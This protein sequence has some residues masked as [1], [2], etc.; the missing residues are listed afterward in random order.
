MR[1]KETGS[2]ELTNLSRTLSWLMRKKWNRQ[3]NHP[4]PL[5]HHTAQDLCLSAL[6]GEKTVTW[7]CLQETI[8]VLGS[9]SPPDIELGG[10]VQPGKHLLCATL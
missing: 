8:R 9:P 4:L 1:V 2:N 7:L 3:Q 10:L 6:Q 5:P